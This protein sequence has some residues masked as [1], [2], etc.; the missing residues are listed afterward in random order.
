MAL[1]TITYQLPAH[2][3][4]THITAVNQ[5]ITS[6]LLYYHGKKISNVYNPSQTGNTLGCDYKFE[7]A[8]DIITHVIMGEIL[9]KIFYQF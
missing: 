8:R 7:T 5:S 4:L 3:G 9:F 6:I 1:C 2:K